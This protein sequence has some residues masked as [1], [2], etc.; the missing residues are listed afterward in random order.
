M[1]V[2]SD[3]ALRLREDDGDLGEGGVHA[4]LRHHQGVCRA[5]ERTLLY[6]AVRARNNGLIPA[7]AALSLG[8]S[9]VVVLFP[10]LDVRLQGV[11]Q[12]PVEELIVPCTN[13]L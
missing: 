12:P 4:V 6:F 13:I 5:F 8:V 11:G 7:V 9:A 1:A 2:F 3:G 10:A